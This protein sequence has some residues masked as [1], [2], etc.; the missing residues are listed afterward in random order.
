MAKPLDIL[1]VSD[2]WPPHFVG[3][4]E[5]GAADVCKRLTA[6]GHRVTVLT[7]TFGVPGPCREGNVH[8]VLSET[9]QGWPDGLGELLRESVGS[10]K[11]LRR[12][13]AFLS[14]ARFDLVYLFNPLGLTASFVQELGETGRPVVA[15]VSDN[16]AAAW[17]ACDRLLARWFKPRMAL[18]ATREIALVLLRQAWRR[19]GV[20]T[21]RPDDLPIRHMQFVSRYIHDITVARW[22]ELATR[23]IIPWGID[24]GRFRIRE[25]RADELTEWLVVGQVV[26]HKGVQ[27]VIEAVQRL[28]ASGHPVRVTFHGTDATPFARELKERVARQRC[29]EYVRFG[30]PVPREQLPDVYDRGGL[31]VFASM[32]EEPFSITV[33]EAFAAGIPVLSTVTGGTPEI[34]RERETATTF[35]AGDAG[36]LAARFEDLVQ[37]PGQALRMAAHARAIVEHHLQIEA[38]VDRVEAHLIAVTEGLGSDRIEPFAPGPHPWEAADE[39]A[40]ALAWPASAS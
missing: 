10:L 39:A 23:E 24:V 31:L 35:R 12:A 32:W 34:V 36:H 27:T 30:G 20:L 2:L 28:R 37:S 1:V 7:S 6:R 29:D 18:P 21:R 19:L 9:V 33:L 17:P 11:G 3:G 22:P 8:R 4:Y 15:Y 16:W 40:P 14:N 5:L 38:M 13:R 26:E 25:R